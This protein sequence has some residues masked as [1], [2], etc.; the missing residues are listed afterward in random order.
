[1]PAAGTGERRR[2]R[3]EA[4]RARH[5][6]RRRAI[7]FGAV[8]VGLLGALVALVAFGYRSLSSVGDEPSPLQATGTSVVADPPP[9]PLRALVVHQGGDGSVVGVTVAVVDEDGAGGNVVLVPVGSMV[10]VASFGLSP[11]RDAFDLGDLP[12][13]R[14]AVENLFGFVFDEVALLAPVDLVDLVVS[15]AGTGG[16]RVELEQP[17]EVV[18]AAGR[19]ETLFP[20][21]DVDVAPEAVPALIEQRGS[22]T[23]LDRLVRH[24]AFWEALLGAVTAEPS[25]P[26]P[27][28]GAAAGLGDVLRAL[29]AGD[30][31]YDILPVEV[32]ATGTGPSDDLYA[33]RDAELDSLVADITGDGAADDERVRVQVLNGTGVPGLAQEVQP[34]LVPAGAVVSLTGNADSFE[35]ET[36]QVVFYRDEDLGAA[37][38]IR[39]ALGVGEVVRS[40]V[41]LDVVDVTVVVGADFVAE[42]TEP[43]AG[44]TGA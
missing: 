21:G 37:R 18:T 36:S 29:A 16:L 12:L 43:D 34:L 13:L 22:G 30:V 32:L 28:V 39:R 23:D 26:V 41:P 8:V 20:A 9:P 10:E 5:L 38:E 25:S 2:R 19:V 42:P 27:S 1:M 44:G 14:Q 40:L 24:Q 15:V 6:G 4:T 7:G 31:R 33:V 3:R 35:Y 11:L 17:V